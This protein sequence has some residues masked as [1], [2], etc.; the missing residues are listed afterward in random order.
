[1]TAVLRLL[2]LT[3][4]YGR[5][6]ALDHVDLSVEHGEVFGYL[7]P[8]GA[9]K[10]TTIRLLMG[11]LRPTAGRAE[12]FGLDVWRD[13][14]LAHACTG[15]LPGDAGLYERLTGQDVVTYFAELRHR[16]ADVTTAEDLAKRFDLDLRRRV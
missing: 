7:G 12:V 9:G 13:R 15:Y 3:K 8:N 4:D 14:V 11:L 5:Q 1:M 6:R 16:R 10:T 2:G